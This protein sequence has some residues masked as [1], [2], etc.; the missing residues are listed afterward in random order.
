[1]A[2]KFKMQNVKCKIKLPRPMIY[3]KNYDFSFSGLKTAVLYLVKQLTIGNKQLTMKQVR[4]IC[5]EVQQ[6]IIDVLVHKTLKAAKEYRAKAIILGGGVTANEE[7]R[8]QIKR[9]T[10]KEIPNVKCLIPD[11]KFCTD[12]AVMTA[13]TGYFNRRE[14]KK[15]EKGDEDKSSSSP[16][17]NARVIEADANLR[18]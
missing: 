4:E 8:K 11:A 6:A 1:M 13:V 14:K 12:N 2:V 3:Q 7:L 10:R 5:A 15:P 18:L 9:R 16:F 17:A